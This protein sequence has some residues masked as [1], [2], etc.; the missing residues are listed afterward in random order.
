MNFSNVTKKSKNIFTAIININGSNYFGKFY[1]K[2]NATF[3]D[4]KKIKRG[5]F[6]MQV[7]CIEENLN[8]LI[9]NKVLIPC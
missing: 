3:I 2:N 5:L 4:I 8:I 7:E 6:G 1:N 9:E